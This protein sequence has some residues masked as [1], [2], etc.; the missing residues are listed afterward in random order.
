MINPLRL[1]AFLVCTLYATNTI[2]AQSP[3]PLDS[4]LT[5]HQADRQQD[6]ASI[7]RLI[8]ISR[9]YYR[10]NPNKGIEYADQAIDLS[11]RVQDNI[12]LARAYGI[13]ALNLLQTGDYPQ[14]TDLANQA[15][16]ILAP[17][18]LKRDMAPLYNT[19]GGAAYYQS[20]IKKAQEYFEKAYR[21]FEALGDAQNAGGCLNNVGLIYLQTA[22]LDQALAIFTKVVPVFEKLKDWSKLA[23]AYDNI[24]SVHT[25]RADYNL[26]LSYFQKALDL[27]TRYNDKIG[28]SMRNGNIAVVYTRLA[29]YPQAV[30]YYQAALRLNEELGDQQ[31]HAI[32]RSNIGFMYLLLGDYPRALDHLEKAMEES[33]K[34]GFNSL[35]AKIYGNLGEV[36]EKQSEYL[37]AEEQYLKCIAAQE[38][39]QQPQEVAEAKNKLAGIYGQKED[40]QKAFE[41]LLASHEVS[42]TTGY[43]SNTIACKLEL[44]SVF[45]LAPDSVLSSQGV[46]PAN[47]YVEALKWQTAGLKMAQ[48]TKMRDLERFAWEMLSNTYEKMGDY[49][50]AYAAFKNYTTI[51]DSIVGEDTKKQITRKE[52][53]YEFDNKEAALKFE[54]QITLEQLEKQKLLSFQQQQSLRLNEQALTL[55]NQ[56]KD[57][58]RLAYLKEKAEKEDKEQQLTLAEKDKLLQE[59]QLGSLVQEKAL[60]LKTLSQKK[61]LV[62][63]LIAGI[64]A[65]LLCFAAAFL[66]MR[67]KQAKKAALVQAQFTRQL[68]EN[69]EDERGRIAGDL[70]DSVSYELLTLKHSIRDNNATTGAGDKID[71]IINGIRQISRNL[72]P[73]MLDKIGLALSLETLCEQFMQHET[74]FVSHAIDYNNSLPKTAELQLFRIVQEGLTNALKYAKAEA[75]KVQLK[76]SGHALQLKIRDNGKGFDVQKALD[77][78]EAFGLHSILQRAKAIGGEAEIRSDKSGTTIRVVTSVKVNHRG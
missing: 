45:Y 27:N 55:S 44:G 69:I 49:N 60:H 50:S 70:H 22:E 46:A 8:A 25:E 57:L 59:V 23:Q 52:I 53:Q 16:D 64:A 13:K 9:A 36:Y 37:K 77:S 30:N 51:R 24:A 41:Y 18:D 74:L 61:A 32:N 75:V 15:L 54:K 5:V 4:L 26:A 6:T 40:F 71:G 21:M 1:I 35:T 12:F 11:N 68:L 33:Q 65:I 29:D 14:L 28:M 20:E 47:R 72:H 7:R 2:S 38:A 58:Q 63:F 56:E 42:T 78:G 67:Q 76:H 66:W 34:L 31:S 39:A 17:L 62:G 43:V 73:V 3:S 10:V 48:E 19:L